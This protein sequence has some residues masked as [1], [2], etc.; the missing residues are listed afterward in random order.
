MSF[1]GLHKI[2]L[3]FFLIM[4]TLCLLAGDFIQYISP[5]SGAKYVSVKTTL[6]V[7][8]YDNW[9]EKLEYFSPEIDVYGEKSGTH[10]GELHIADDGIT[11][12]FKPDRQFLTN[13]RVYIQITA[14][15]PG[16][17]QPLS[18]Y[19]KT[20]KSEKYDDQIFEEKHFEFDKMASSNQYE[21]YGALTVIN[22]VSVPRDFPQLIIDT[23]QNTEPGR[24]FLTTEGGI[25]YILI[26]E[27]DGT[28]YFYQ[29]LTD[30]S[31]DFK[32]Q[33]TGTLT[34]RI[35]GEVSGY[36]EMDSNFQIIDT[37]SCGNGYGTDSHEAQIL[38]NVCLLL[39]IFNI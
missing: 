3:M 11:F 7:R 9:Q 36:V 1:A 13:E 30:Y 2:Y 29:R 20:S 24:L 5:Q 33:T 35:R 22:G 26:L 37:L 27:N 6:I 34:R 4:P 18:Y 38:P 15:L 10:K 21:P 28:P 16:F 17:N 39:L 19:F 23:L 14:N 31:R 32:V 12:I 25:P 8:F